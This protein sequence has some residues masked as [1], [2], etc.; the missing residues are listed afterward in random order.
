MMFIFITRTTHSNSFNLL[1]LKDLQVNGSHEIIKR[2]IANASIWGNQTQ[3]LKAD[4]TWNMSQ[5]Q[6]CHS[7]SGKEMNTT[8]RYDRHPRTYELELPMPF[9]W[10]PMC[11]TIE[12]NIHFV[13]LLAAS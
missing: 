2:S 8:I 6:E 11:Q 3:H 13:T 5:K 12:R 1:A 10:I 4:E 7:H 9:M